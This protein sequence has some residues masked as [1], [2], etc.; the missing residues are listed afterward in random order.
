LPA[1]A[2]IQTDSS[3][4]CPPRKGS[5]VHYS[6]SFPRSR[7]GTKIWDYKHDGVAH[8]GMLPDF[9]EDARTLPNGKEVVDQGMM[10]GADYFL[11]TWKKCEELR[12]SVPMN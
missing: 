12:S 8:Y 9:L 2:P 1:S 6:D 7:L 10:L 3:P 4:A 5:A 11:E